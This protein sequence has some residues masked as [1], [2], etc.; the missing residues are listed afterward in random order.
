M[1]IPDYIKNETSGLIKHDKSFDSILGKERITIFVPERFTVNEAYW[2]QFIPD[3]QLQAGSI[4]KGEREYKYVG[5]EIIHI[6]YDLEPKLEQRSDIRNLSSCPHP[7]C[8]YCLQIMKI[9]TH[10]ENGIYRTIKVGDHFSFSA[11]ANLIQATIW[12]E[13]GKAQIFAYE[14]NREFMKSEIIDKYGPANISTFG[15]RDLRTIKVYAI[16]DESEGEKDNFT[17]LWIHLSRYN[18]ESWP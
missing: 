10:F 7:N 2:N 12:I 17:R 4:T 8:I 3:N 1:S 18:I 11:N 6:S 13:H 16:P 9:K 5:K 14:G 15:R